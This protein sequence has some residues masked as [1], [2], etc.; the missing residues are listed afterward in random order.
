MKSLQRNKLKAHAYLHYALSD[1]FIYV[2]FVFE[3]V[4][5]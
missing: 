3:C 1:A 5:L 2:L 4:I